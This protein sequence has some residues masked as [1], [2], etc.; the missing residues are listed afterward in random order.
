MRSIKKLA[1]MIVLAMTMTMGLSVLTPVSAKG[2]IYVERTSADTEAPKSD[3]SATATSIVISSLT[4]IGI[5]IVSS[6]S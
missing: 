5:I 3:E 4:N 2:I 1:A 6:L